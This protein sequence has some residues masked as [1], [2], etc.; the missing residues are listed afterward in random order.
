MR[1]HRFERKFRQLGERVALW[2]QNAAIPTI[3]RHHYQVG[4]QFQRLGGDSE[5]HGTV[6]RHF[7]YLHGCALVHMQ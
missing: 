3:A 5:I 6:C 4:E 2:H 7:G 1:C